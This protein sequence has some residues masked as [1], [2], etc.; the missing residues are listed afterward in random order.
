MVEAT[1]M[2]SLVEQARAGDASAFESLVE[3]RVDAMYRLSFAILGD[4][5]DAADAVQESLIE[6]W[7]HL[8]KLREAD[9]FG[10]WLERIVVNS[11]RMSI[12][13]RSRRRVREMP[14][15]GLE[16]TPEAMAGATTVGFD[17]RAGRDEA[18]LRS[19]VRRLPPD[20]NAILALH[21]FE[22]RSLAEIAEVLS[23]PVG[24]AKSR[25]FKARVELVKAI[26]EEGRR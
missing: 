17:D 19:A 2:R 5:T 12:R 20:Q 25:L 21:Y 1:A 4:E 18:L 7:R 10:A 26:A 13:A 16:T 24:T 14:M 15:G 22:G 9:R 3:S 6:A 11:C 23:I 8:P